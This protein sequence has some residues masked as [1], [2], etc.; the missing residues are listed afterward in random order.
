MCVCVRDQGLYTCVTYTLSKKAVC[1][2]TYHH[3]WFLVLAKAY[4]RD[5]WKW[6]F[7]TRYPTSGLYAAFLE[8]YRF[9]ISHVLLDWSGFDMCWSSHHWW[10]KANP[11][12]QG[13]LSYDLVTAITHH[14]QQ[15][16][17]SSKSQ[18]SGSIACQRILVC[19]LLFCDLC[20]SPIHIW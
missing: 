12:I 19:A 11:H 4:R 17:Y 16:R 14:Q 5:R 13:S 3:I 20:V 8:S 6:I 18:E 7:H 2:N 1:C 9:T 15:S 10:Y